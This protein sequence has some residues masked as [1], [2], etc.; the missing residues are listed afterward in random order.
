M[1]STQVFTVVFV[2]LFNPMLKSLGRILNDQYF[3]IFQGSV[4]AYC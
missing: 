1:F 3:A 4:D 2:P